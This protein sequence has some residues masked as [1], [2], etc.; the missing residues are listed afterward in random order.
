MKNLT[1]KIKEF[2]EWIL[3]SIVIYPLMLISDSILNKYIILSILTITSLGVIIYHF[4]KLKTKKL[5]DSIYLFFSYLIILL[6]SIV[7]AGIFSFIDSW[8]IIQSEYLLYLGIS[9]SIF[10]IFYFI[11]FIKNGIKQ[12]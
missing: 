10:L 4:N 8:F 2:K 5:N 9:Q 3:F 1:E 6:L 7:I 12:P 11:I